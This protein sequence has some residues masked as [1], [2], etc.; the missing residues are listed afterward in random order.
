[1]P[2]LADDQHLYVRAMGKAVRVTALFPGDDAA[3]TYMA[4]HPDE[5]VIAEI[6]GIVFIARVRDLGVPFQ[7]KAPTG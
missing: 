5:G 1:M 2:K 3:N 7:P 4:L 6:G